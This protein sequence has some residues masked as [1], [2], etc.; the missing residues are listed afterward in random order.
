LLLYEPLGIKIKIY[1]FCP[2]TVFIYFVSISEQT[3]VISLYSINWLVFITKTE[4]VYCAVR[5]GS[6]NIT[7]FYV[8]FEGLTSMNFMELEPTALQ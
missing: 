5:T 2:H 1:S 3:A 4:Y 6:L 8:I 7:Q